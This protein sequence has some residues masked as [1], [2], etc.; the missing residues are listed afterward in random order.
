[1]KKSIKRLRGIS[2]HG[3]IGLYASGAAGKSW[4]DDFLTG[5]RDIYILLNFPFRFPHLLPSLSSCAGFVSNRSYG[6]DSFF[7]MLF[8]GKRLKTLA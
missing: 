3:A 1:V 5:F 6:L 2:L 4:H 8:S 7:D